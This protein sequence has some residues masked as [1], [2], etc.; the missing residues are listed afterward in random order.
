[1][2]FFH[3]MPFFKDSAT[4][5]PWLSV[6]LQLILIHFNGAEVQYQ[7]Q[8]VDSWGTVSV[9]VDHNVM[10]TGDTEPPSS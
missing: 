6:V 5:A 7:A 9:S 2:S 10:Q 4:L 3:H 8:A 1:M